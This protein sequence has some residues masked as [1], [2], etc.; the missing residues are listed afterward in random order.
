MT[1]KKKKLSDLSRDQCATLERYLYLLHPHKSFSI[2]PEVLQIFF[3]VDV[4][5]YKIIV[6]W[7]KPA[8]GWSKATSIVHSSLR[9]MSCPLKFSVEKDMKPCISIASGVR[10]IDKISSSD[11]ISGNEEEIIC[12]PFASPN[13]SV[14]G[15][16]AATI[17]EGD[18]LKLR[19]SSS[20]IWEVSEI[21][22]AA[23]FVILAV[24]KRSEIRDREC[25][26]VHIAEKRRFIAAE[27]MG[28]VVW[29]ER[30]PANDANYSESV[31]EDSAEN[32][33]PV[34][35]S[36][37]CI[38]QMPTTPWKHVLQHMKSLVSDHIILHG[39]AAGGVPFSTQGSSE[40]GLSRRNVNVDDAVPYSQRG[41]LRGADVKFSDLISGTNDKPHKGTSAPYISEKITSIRIDNDAA[42]I[43][44]LSKENTSQAQIWLDGEKNM[45]Q[46]RLLLLTADPFS[47][48][49]A[50]CRDR[51]IL[52][53]R[54]LKAICRGDENLLKD[55]YNWTYSSGLEGEQRAKDCKNVWRALRPLTTADLPCV[56]RARVH[57]R[58]IFHAQHVDGGV[59]EEQVIGGR[60]R[61][62]LSLRS[63]EAFCGSDP[64]LKSLFDSTASILRDRCLYFLS[65]MNN[66]LCSN[67]SKFPDDHMVVPAAM[68]EAR[69]SAISDIDFRCSNQQYGGTSS[70]AFIEVGEVVA[71]IS[72]GDV[73]LLPSFQSYAPTCGRI[74]EN[75]GQ[76]SAPISTDKE[77]KCTWHRVIAIDLLY[78]R[79]RVSPCPPPP[80]CWNRHVTLPSVWAPISCLW[81]VSV[82]QLMP[83]RSPQSCLPIQYIIFVTP[84]PSIPAS[85]A[86][87]ASL[88]RKDEILSSARRIDTLIESVKKVKF[89][90]KR[91]KVP[92]DYVSQISMS[93]NKKRENENVMRRSPK[94]QPKSRG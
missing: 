11:S 86:A 17:Y 84:I 7:L 79:L 36:E 33:E 83:P 15:M 89:K 71:K 85:F 91:I 58:S 42:A 78:A 60:E 27:L 14:E 74:P 52:T 22:P 80:D 9:L 57:I 5:L 23:S 64:Q 63:I 62:S 20:I 34:A 70:A 21:N 65:S 81:A 94:S 12:V 90:K 38:F 47:C 45:V 39:E 37:S 25:V 92:T 88:P 49:L 8:F 26:T 55:F 41:R 1:S 46:A 18:L 2:V 48:C 50:S 68:Y 24:Y 10:V 76:Q 72:P 87:L 51:W 40:G 66:G 67:A 77:R 6:D 4:C 54:A 44:G 61:S 75:K 93:I 56:V 16:I 73:L 31:D 19:C 3:C 59:K 32:S 43:S 69:E 53:C 29:R 28:A 30:L 82:C 13:G 35:A